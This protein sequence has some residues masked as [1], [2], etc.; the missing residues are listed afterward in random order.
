V[1]QTW[2]IHAGRPIVPEDVPADLFDQLQ[3]AC[4]PDF[5]GVQCFKIEKKIRRP[6]FNQPESIRLGDF[7]S[8]GNF[9]ILTH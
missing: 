4:K 7:A 2:K 8:H 9:D 6:I 1:L 5:L 3:S